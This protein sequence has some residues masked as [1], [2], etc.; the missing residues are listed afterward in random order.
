MVNRIHTKRFA[1]L[2]VSEAVLPG[3]KTSSAQNVTSLCEHFKLH[4]ID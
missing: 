4:R 1:D 3:L 2:D